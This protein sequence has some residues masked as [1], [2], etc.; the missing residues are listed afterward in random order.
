LRWQPG[1]D[2][3]LHVLDGRAAISDKQEPVRAL[4][5]LAFNP[6]QDIPSSAEPS[7]LSKEFAAVHESY[8][9]TNLSHVKKLVAKA[10]AVAMMEIFRGFRTLSV[11]VKDLTPQSYPERFTDSP[12]RKVAAQEN[13]CWPGCQISISDSAFPDIG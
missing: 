8:F 13:I 7:D 1:A 5:T 12:A 3:L 10:L 9:R 6:D 4:A 11:A 2:F